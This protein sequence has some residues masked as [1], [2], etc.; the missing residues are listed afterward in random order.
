MTI[1]E[2]ERL[3]LI[4][5]HHDVVGRREGW[6]EIIPSLRQFRDWNAHPYWLIPVV[7][8]VNMSVGITTA[9][10]IQ[11]Y[12]AIACRSLY[13]KIQAAVVTTSSI[14]GAVS[15]G[16]WCRFGD[17]Y[18]RKPIFVLYLLGA[19]FSECVYV[20]VMRSNTIFSRYAEHFILLGPILEGLTGGL[21]TFLGLFHARGYLYCNCTRHG[22]RSKIFSTIY[23]IFYIGLS[24][25][26]LL[27]W[28][29][30]QAHPLIH[31]STLA[32]QIWR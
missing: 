22:S 29:C 19:I 23:G 5:N 15:T 32:W 21:A 9:P 14:L 10:E 30:L 2:E 11:V 17:A 13:A 16:F 1:S 12:K 6:M 7:I 3:L 25:G 8:A 4:P 28:S 26:P 27:A 20:L 18:G 24:A 31:T